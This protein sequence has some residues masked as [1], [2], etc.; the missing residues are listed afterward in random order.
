MGAC[1]TI[2]CKMWSLFSEAVKER[3]GSGLV[4]HR[5]LSDLLLV[6]VWFEY[7]VEP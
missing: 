2:A 3:G 5:L 7:G 1:L 6:A 4:K